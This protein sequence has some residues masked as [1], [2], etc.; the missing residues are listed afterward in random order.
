LTVIDEQGGRQK[1]LRFF[2]RTEHA[3]H[4]I[5]DSAGQLQ[6]EP[7]IA[8]QGRQIRIELHRALLDRHQLLI[9]NPTVAQFIEIGLQAF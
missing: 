2:I 4:Q 9:R 1:A 7:D 6:A 8:I 3:T 5:L